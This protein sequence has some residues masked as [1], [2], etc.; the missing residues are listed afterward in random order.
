MVLTNRE[1]K[2]LNVTTLHLFKLRGW[3]VN[4]HTWATWMG[5]IDTTTGR[6]DRN[7]DII[8]VG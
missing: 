3:R 1:L 8:L 4:D 2:V 5:H 6:C 7:S